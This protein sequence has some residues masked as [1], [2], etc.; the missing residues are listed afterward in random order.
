MTILRILSAEAVDY[1]MPLK[2]PYG[3][4]RGITRSARNFIVRLQ[5]RAADGAE[6][7]GLGE[8]Q[9]RHVLTGDGPRNGPMAWDFL[10]A[11]VA[12]LRGCSLDLSDRATAVAGIRAL[13]AEMD[14]LA[15]DHATEVNADKPFRGTL[16]GI[17]VALLDIAARALNCQIADLLGRHRDTIAI[18]ISTISTATGMA[19]IADKVARQTRYPITRVKGSGDVDKDVALFEQ[20]A[21]ANQS[22]GRDKPI[23]M[24][25]NEASTR[26]SAEAFIAR[27]A[28]LMLRGR[29]P[30]RI[31]LEGM[32]PKDDFLQLA[33]LQVMAD[34]LCL[35]LDP[36]G[37]L[38]LRI[39]PDEGLWD[40]DDM[41]ALNARGGC[42]AI[43]LK[44]PKA[45][46]LLASIDLVEAALQANPDVH[47]SVGG[48]LATSDLTAFALH[49]LGRA[50]PRLD[51]ITATPPGNV[52]ARIATPRARYTGKTSNVIAAQTGNGLGTRLDAAALEPFVTDRAGAAGR[53]THALVFGGD[54][55]LGDKHHL[56]KGGDTKR[57][58]LE[59][60]MSFLRGLQ[61]LVAQSDHLILN[62]ESVLEVDPVSPLADRKNYLGWDTPERTLAC[63]REL[64]VTAVGMGNNHAMDF[65]PE[66][67]ARTIA[68]LEEAGICVFGAGPDRERAEAPLTLPLDFGGETRNVHIL[69]AKARER[70]LA[71]FGFFA[72]DDSPGV[73]LLSLERMGAQIRQLKQEDPASLVIVYPH[74]NFDYKWPTPRLRE[75]G[76]ALIEA[77]A[78][79]VIGHG[80]H[81]MNDFTLEGGR[82][83]VWSLGNFQFNWAG[84]YAKMPEAVPYSLVARLVLGLEDGAW[85]TDLRLYPTRCDNPAL[86]YQPRPVT[87]AEAAE[88]AEILTR[89]AQEAGQPG[90]YSARQDDIGW[91]VVVENEYHAAQGIIAAENNDKTIDIDSL[92]EKLPRRIS[93]GSSTFLLIEAAL[94]AGI[95]LNVVD[96]NVQGEINSSGKAFKIKRGTVLIR[97]EDDATFG[98]IDRKA[99]NIVSDKEKTKALLR[100]CG[101]SVAHGR[102]FSVD[103][104]DH[105]RDFLT[106]LKSVVIKP[107]DGNKGRG[108]CVGV[109]PDSF[110]TAWE[111]AAAN[112][113]SGVIVEQ[114]FRG[115]L[116][117][118]YLVI[119]G[120]L[121]CVLL[122]TP[123]MVVG[124]GSK[125]IAELVEIKNAERRKNR[126]LKNRPIVLDKFRIALLHDKG[127]KTD[128]I[129][130]AGTKIVLDV[131]SSFSS[132]GESWDFTEEVHPSFREIVEHAFNSIDDLRFAGIDVMARDHSRPASAD[133]YIIVE[134]NTTP[135]LGG[136]HFPLHGTPRN[137]ARAIIRS[138]LTRP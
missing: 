23:W 119:D 40:A 36:E 84:R 24:D 85:T 60:P 76:Q 58:L 100:S 125:T 21:A 13:M 62:F 91:H 11:A 56:A 35:G 98:H 22:L 134:V 48:M 73:A 109:T 37:G 69:G 95:P 128:S 39:M 27:L 78:D 104:N 137:P 50:L 61:P 19:G 108:V 64:G 5:G 52:A 127:L 71:E 74:W 16:L 113:R 103:E 81:I 1:T 25:I 92:V 106:S 70:K 41:A 32:L 2:R 130:A 115:G 101:L 105:A 116:E 118:R 9:P 54:T 17:E 20:I 38:D 138:L 82:G 112:T 136:H 111:L 4:A 72:T 124:D 43:N 126:H 79:L 75:R 15:R 114:E 47:V 34:A 8:C 28:A 3:T 129:P 65:G 94:D 90:R 45:G 68:R 7:E 97:N 18:S 51:Y 30:R 87:E 29:L 46:G 89:K 53:R 12:R 14:G 49:N 80:T 59:D 133:N 93:N 66:I 44:A 107:N 122:K 123:P 117:A 57:R 135:A 55:S 67:M 121:N 110:D 88:V 131:K 120:K 77:G 96:G 63:L 31:L 26:Q 102:L 42:R 10:C 83:I 6:H 99:V 33:D 86:D 132:G